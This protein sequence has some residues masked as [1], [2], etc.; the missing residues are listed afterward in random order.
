MGSDEVSADLVVSASTVIPEAELR[1]R[2]SRSSGPGGQAVNTTDSRVELLWDA[3]AS[4]VLTPVQ[5]SRLLARV[6]DGVLRVV[7]SEHRSQ[8]QNRRAARQ[9]MAALV[10]AATAKP[11]PVR[12]P[13]RPSRSA[14]ERRL[15][16]KHRRG[17]IK[18]QR[19]TRDE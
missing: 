2:F 3:G 7:A 17:E 13:T 6:P 19:R 4:T 10:R 9:R 11:P 18:R 1:W 14:V 8:W 5:R 16:A 12:R 15:A